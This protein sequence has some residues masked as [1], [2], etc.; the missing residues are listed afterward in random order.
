MLYWWIVLA[1]AVVAW[2]SAFAYGFSIMWFG[3]DPKFGK[4]DFSAS[5]ATGFFLS[6]VMPLM[7]FIMTVVDFFDR[8]RRIRREVARKRR[9]AKREKAAS[10]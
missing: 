9:K 6:T 5:L 8:I 10:A 2:V 1:V 3:E 4:H 7:L